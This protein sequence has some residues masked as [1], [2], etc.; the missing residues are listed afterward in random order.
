MTMTIRELVMASMVALALGGCSVSF[1][2]TPTSSSPGYNYGYGSAGKPLA[3]ADYG[4]GKPL[5]HGSADDDDAQ[6]RVPKGDDSTKPAER[7]KPEPTTKPPT[8]DPIDPPPTKPD[9]RKPKPEPTKVPPELRKPTTRKPNPEPTKVPPELRKP[10]TRKPKPE[11]VPGLRDGTA[12]LDTRRA[13][14]RPAPTR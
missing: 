9:T 14:L 10:T 8:R 13:V 11:P 12:K 6:P 3:S 5:H 7:K 2:G 4:Q 1:M